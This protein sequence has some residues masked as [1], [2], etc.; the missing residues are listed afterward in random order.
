MYFWYSDDLFSKVSSSSQILLSRRAIPLER[1]ALE[2][3]IG[4]LTTKRNDNRNN[5]KNKTI[6]ENYKLIKKVLAEKVVTLEQKI[7]SRQVRKLSRD[8][9]RPTTSVRKRNRRFKKDVIVN[10]RKEKRKRY[11][12]KK[13]QS[14]KEIKQNAPDQ[15]AINLSNSV[16]RAKITTKKKVLLLY[17]LQ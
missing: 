9:I 14:I 11:R 6:R 3:E 8:N 5:I 15:N 12:S 4:T 10:K 1:K 7:K 2:K 16:R 17:R 13:K